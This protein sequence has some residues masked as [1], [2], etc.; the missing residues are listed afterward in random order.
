[1]K[2]C[3][4]PNKVK[5]TGECVLIPKRKYIIV[6]GEDLNLFINLRTIVGFITVNLFGVGPMIFPFKEKEFSP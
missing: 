1:M 3:Y 5:I 2:S 6:F 4:I